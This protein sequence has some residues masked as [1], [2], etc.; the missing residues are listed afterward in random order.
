M[1]T[2]QASHSTTAIAGD[3]V[4]EINNIKSPITETFYKERDRAPLKTAEQQ[5]TDRTH[6]VFNTDCCDEFLN[7]LTESSGRTPASTMPNTTI[8]NITDKRI[9]SSGT[10][11][12]CELK[13]VWVPVKLV[14]KCANGT[15]L[16]QELRERT[17]PSGTPKDVEKQEANAFTNGSVLSR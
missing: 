3:R 7:S 16:Y 9:R 10:Q 1:R 8:T 11:Y 15:R 4:L 6:S 14:R 17:R 2:I 13:P 5:R 12:K